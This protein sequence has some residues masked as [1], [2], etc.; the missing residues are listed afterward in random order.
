MGCAWQQVGGEDI[1]APACGFKDSV[2][3]VG[4]QTDRC[5][6]EDAHGGCAVSALGRRLR[7]LFISHWN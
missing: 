1:G 4:T 2:Q 3:D 5:V 7:R 6:V